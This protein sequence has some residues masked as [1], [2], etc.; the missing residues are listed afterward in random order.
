MRRNLPLWL[1]GRIKSQKQGLAPNRHQKVL[2]ELNRT[3]ESEKG[4]PST[5]LC[6]SSG[7]SSELVSILLNSFPGTRSCIL[8]PS[9][10]ETDSVAVDSALWENIPGYVILKTEFSVSIL[11]LEVRF[12]AACDL[13]KARRSVFAKDIPLLIWNS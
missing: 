1:V 10:V 11:T 9:K 7:S 3:A 2:V 6:V 4:H 8:N 12:E 5:W 13:L